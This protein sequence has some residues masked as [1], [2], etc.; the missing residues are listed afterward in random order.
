MGAVSSP[1]NWK[2]SPK[3]GAGK[4]VRVAQWL[5]A[6]NLRREAFDRIFFYSDSRND[7]RC[8]SR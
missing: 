4:V 6:Q 2:A 3:L 1:A 8:W 7:I 5:Q